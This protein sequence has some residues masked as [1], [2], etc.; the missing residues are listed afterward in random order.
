MHNLIR[1]IYG[2]LKSRNAFDAIFLDH[3]LDFQ[4]GI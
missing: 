4:D 2:V 3:R 1:Q